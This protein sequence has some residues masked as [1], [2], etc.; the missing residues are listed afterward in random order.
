MSADKE[1]TV[2]RARG[3]VPTRD[4]AE[5]CADFYLLETLTA[6]GDESARKEL[7]RLEDRLAEEF[8]AYLDVAVG[9]ELRYAKNH[10]PDG[11]LPTELAC[12]FREI[13][14]TRRGRAWMVW[15]IVRRV[16]GLRAIELA[17]EVFSRRDWPENF[18]GWAWA[19]VVRLLR[20]YLQG[21][22][23]ARVFVDQCFSLEHNTGSIFN[24][25]YDTA[26][27][28]RAL[29]AQST[30]DY[31]ALCVF[32]SRSVNRR[33]RLREWEKRQEHDPTWLG[34]QVL[35][36]YEEMVGEGTAHVG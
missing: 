26:R 22:L 28:S 5:A 25:L 33:W 15:T 18:G 27:L 12:F 30:D 34:V 10:L 7:T 23:C 36:T 17:E 9:G 8:C 11:T 13:K 3:C 21:T 19:Q 24:K 29:V 4:L 14:P 1:R 32:A 31:E 2:A 16:H 20:G 6:C 35:D